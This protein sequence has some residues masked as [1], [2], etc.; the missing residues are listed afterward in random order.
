MIKFENLIYIIIVLFGFIIPFIYALYKNKVEH[1]IK[2]E[3]FLYVYIIYI[4]AFLF[5]AKISYV[6]FNNPNS[7]YY[8]LFTDSIKYKLAFVLSGYSFWGG[9][10][11]TMII[12]QY[13]LLLIKEKGI[14][15]FSMSSLL[16]Y[17]ILKI[18][19]LIKGCCSGHGK[20]P[21]PL[22]EIIIIFVLFLL[23]VFLEKRKYKKDNL[24]ILN[25]LL[26]SIERFI[27][28]FFRS[29]STTNSFYFNE[30]SSIIIIFICY[31]YYEHKIK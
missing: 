18:G 23:I 27:V 28:G 14:Y 11:G 2:K 8:I 12:I 22:L 9:Y 25:I 19:C 4:F 7:I 5:F 26:F 31:I 3:H 29:F 15:I 1:I 30:M 24:T 17:S 16:M 13:F 6:V 21:I 10:I 20:I